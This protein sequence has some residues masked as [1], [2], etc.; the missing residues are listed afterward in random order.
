MNCYDNEVRA[1]VAARLTGG[2]KPASISETLGIPLR[3]IYRMRRSFSREGPLQNR[4][5]AVPLLARV[6]RSGI[7]REQ[8]LLLPERVK[9]AQR[10][11]WTELTL[12]LGDWSWVRVV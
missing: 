2:Q 8:L 7:S 3:T 1:D 9:D 10:Q 12:E 4:F 6:V 11:G 5:I